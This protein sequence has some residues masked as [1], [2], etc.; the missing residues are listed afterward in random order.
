[1][2]AAWMLFSVMTGCALT[3]AAAAADRLASLSR[4]PRRFIWLTALVVTTC[5]PVISLIRAALF[6]LRDASNS[7]PLLVG[8]AHR[9]TAFAVPVPAWEIPPY[10]VLGLIVGWALCSSVLIGRV[11]LAVWYIRR[12]RATWATIEVDGMCVHLSS[13]A[14]PAVIGLHQMKVVLPE[15][16]LEMERPLRTLVLRH[17]AEHRSARDPYLLLVATVL[18]ALIPWNVPLWFQARRLR[19][20]IEI[21]CD[22]RVLRAHPSWPEYALLLLTIAQRRVRTMQ[23]LTPALSEPTSNL[24]RRIATMSTK[25]TLSRFHTVCLIL[26]ATAALAL[27]CAVDK[28]DSP[29]RLNRSQSVAEHAKP[30]VS[31]QS[32]DPARSTFF[33]FQV[34]KPVTPRE[35]LHVQYPAALKRSGISGE[36]L[37]QFVVD[38]TGRVDMSTFKLLNAPDPQF[39]AAVKAA[40]PTWQLEPATVHGQRVKQLVQQSFVFKLPPDA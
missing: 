15:W 16:I 24:E 20:A 32:L 39:A 10:W 31:A 23:G 25:P 18:P 1:M 33:E 14:G 7:A 6:P 35:S 34:D 3:V 28:P 13:D 22:G 11:A 5:W 40:L 38:Q 21:D 19:L 17:E 37:A 8:E 4:R 12:Q 26:V 2:I 36:V 29:D 30:A 9:L 27:A